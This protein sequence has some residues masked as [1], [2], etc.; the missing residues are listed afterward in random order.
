MRPDAHRTIAEL[1]RLGLDCPRYSAEPLPPYRFVP[2]L[3][4]HPIT[5][6]RGH[7]HGVTA[8][9]PEALPPEA[10]SRCRPYLFGCDLF[11]RGYWWEAHE[12][13]ESLWQVT[14]SRPQ[15]HRFLQ[16][17][18]QAANSHLKLA[19]GKPQAVRRLW[20]KA[21]A[22]WQDT[23]CPDHYMGLPLGSWRRR[24]ARYLETCLQQSPLRHNAAEFPCLC[25]QDLADPAIA[26]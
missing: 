19:L 13:W 10:W 22:H 1:S 7:S 9:Q 25:L 5:D 3:T 20:S 6:P 2:G 23:A 8:E 15:Q 4:P 18:I 17:L 26:G 12:A 14:R 21:E 11:N 24:T 16:G